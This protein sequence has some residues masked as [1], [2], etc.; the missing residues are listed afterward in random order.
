MDEPWVA[1]VTPEAW[2]RVRALF[3]RWE[4]KSLLARMPADGG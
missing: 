1:P 3:E 4:F 2:S